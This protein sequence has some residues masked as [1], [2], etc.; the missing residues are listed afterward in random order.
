MP[1]YVSK[2]NETKHFRSRWHKNAS[3]IVNMKNM[4]TQNHKKHIKHKVKIFSIFADWFRYVLNI[5]LYKSVTWTVSPAQLW[6]N[7][8]DG[9][10]CFSACRHTSSLVLRLVSATH[11]KIRLLVQ[12][13]NVPFQRVLKHRALVSPGPRFR[14]ILL[15]SSTLHRSNMNVARSRQ[16]GKKENLF[17]NLKKKRSKRHFFN[18][19]SYCS[20]C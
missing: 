12:D 9:K 10:V 15:A 13:R 18:V 6:R 14:S 17:F 19:K 16:D 1:Q 5:S 8:G 3:T 2:H 20:T 11:S 4:T 7:M